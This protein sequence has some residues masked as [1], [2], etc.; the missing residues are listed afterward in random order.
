[1]GKRLEEMLDAVLKKGLKEG[2]IKERNRNYARGKRFGN[3]PLTKESE[4]Q[5]KLKLEKGEAVTYV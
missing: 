4:I 1:M 3:I 5:N 2:S